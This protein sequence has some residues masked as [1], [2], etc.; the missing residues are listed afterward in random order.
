MTMMMTTNLEEK[1]D[2]EI[3]MKKGDTLVQRGQ[4]HQ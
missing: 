4:N 3:E 1:E 2:V